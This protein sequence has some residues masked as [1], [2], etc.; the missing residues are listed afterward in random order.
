MK[1]RNLLLLAVASLLMVSCADIKSV[2]YMNNI[3]EIPA[4]ALS[5]AT[6]QVG[7][8]SIKPGKKVTITVT[9]KTYGYAQYYAY[10]AVNFK[11]N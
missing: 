11:Y 5:A 7:D 10:R 2:S 9:V 1:I 3:D 8:F 6:T 4:A